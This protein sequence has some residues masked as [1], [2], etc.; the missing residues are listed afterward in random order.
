M[1]YRPV[2]LKGEG[3]NYFSITDPTSWAEKVINEVSKC[4]FKKCL[5]ANETRERPADFATD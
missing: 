4:K 1:G 2:A 5:F 3:S